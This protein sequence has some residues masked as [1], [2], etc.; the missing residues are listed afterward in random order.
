MAKKIAVT[1][2]TG[3]IGGAVIR[4]ALAAGWEVHSYGRRE[5]TDTEFHQWDAVQMRPVVRGSYDA[6]IHCA[7]AA[8]DWGDRLMISGTN[9]RGTRNALDIDPNA[10]FIHIS[11]ASVY[12]SSQRSGHMLHEDTVLGN[13]FLNFHAQS[14]ADAEKLVLNDN[15]DAGSVI[16]R[17]HAVYGPGDTTLLPRVEQASRRGR[18]LLPNGGDNLAS[19]TRIDNLVKVILEMVE[20]ESFSHKIY[21]VSDGNIVTLRTALNEMLAARGKTVKI[22]GIRPG[23]A[24]RIG[25]SAEWLYNEMEAKKAPPLTRYIVSQLGYEQT[26][27]ISRI[28]N[29][30]GRKMPFSDFSDAASWDRE[31]LFV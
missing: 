1:G 25:K 24:W 17:P 26:L 19:L 9:I 16:L 15:R 27:N 11:T 10:R 3:F 6:I 8:T 31:M 4:A 5:V 14:K 12:S 30:L 18:L 20:I 13:D 29:Q 22:I 28:E 7:A 21:N 2:G 23:I